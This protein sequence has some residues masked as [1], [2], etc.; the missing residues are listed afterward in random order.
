MKQ[1]TVRKIPDYLDKLAREKARKS[2]KSLN[3][4]LLEALARGLDA[5]SQAVYQDMDDLAGTW[6]AD[7]SI[8]AALETFHQ[9]DEDLWK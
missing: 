3:S 5:D 6:V 9:I 4:V 2:Q 1:Y 8:D 7:S